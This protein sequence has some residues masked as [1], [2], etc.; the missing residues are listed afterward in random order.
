MT[1]KRIITQK[2]KNYIETLYLYFNLENASHDDAD[3]PTLKY[4]NVLSYMTDTM[5]SNAKY[6]SNAR[7]R[8]WYQFPN[9]RLGIMSYDKAK[10][11]NQFNCVIQYEQHHLWTLDH[12][13]TGLDLP[14]QVDRKH[15]HIKRIDITKIAKHEPDYLT[16]YGFL[17]TY[18]DKSYDRGTYYL[19]VRYSSNFFRM[20]NK[21]KE[22]T[23]TK[24]YKKMALLS[25]YFGDI[26]NLWT[27][28]LVLDRSFLKSS[29]G[30]TTLDDLSKVYSANRNIVSQIRFYRSTDHNKRLLKNQNQDRMKCLVLT[31]FKEYDR[32]V[33]KRYKPSFNYAADQVLKIVDSYIDNM[34]L[35]R[36]ND[37]YM[38]FVNALMVARVD[39][40]LKDMVITYEDTP[41]SNG[42]AQMTAKHQGM[43]DN[44]SNELELEANRAFK[45]IENSQINSSVQ[46]T[47]CHQDEVRNKQAPALPGL[48]ERV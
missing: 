6:L 34:G 45:K 24:N 28:E 26:E 41:L 9:Y 20:Y 2:E 47:L 11:A 30:I 19:G 7:G 44:Q 33:K 38:K 4:Y 18:R 46:D 8:D 40:K 12:D 21:T 17:S 1:D 27:Y 23:Q 37:E 36:T 31:D 39:Y 35:K 25:E 5:F 10:R 32:V 16:D 14:F 13:L 3:H 15:Y 29:L 48:S 42:M 43:R 22:L